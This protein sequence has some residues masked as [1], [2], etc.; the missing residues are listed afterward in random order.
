MDD[1]LLV[2]IIEM[3]SKLGVKLDCIDIVMMFKIMASFERVMNAINPLCESMYD[4]IY[5]LNLARF[6]GSAISRSIF[7]CSK[8]KQ[9]QH[10]ISA[11]EKY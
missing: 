7:L 4:S 9:Q 11:I 1:R 3:F 2:L 8:L 5:T 10:N 6:Q